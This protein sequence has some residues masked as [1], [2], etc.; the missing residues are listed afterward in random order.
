MVSTGRLLDERK[1][2]TAGPCYDG[3]GIFIFDTNL[4][5]SQAILDSD[6]A[7]ESISAT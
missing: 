7:Y 6:M 4:E 2:I 3:R 5:E 1:M